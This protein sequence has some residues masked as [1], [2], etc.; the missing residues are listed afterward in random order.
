MRWE[1]LGVL[2]ET[3]VSSERLV[4]LIRHFEYHEGFRPLEGENGKPFASYEE[5]CVAGQPFGLGYARPDIE[6]IIAE[7]A[8]IEATAAKAE[9]AGDP[10]GDRPSKLVAA[11]SSP[12]GMHSERLTARIARDRPGILE[13]MKVGEFGSVRATAKEAGIVQDPWERRPLSLHLGWGG[14]PNT[15]GGAVEA[16]LGARAAA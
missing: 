2:K 1:I 7:R 12:T 8:S 11:T 3:T 16:E 15:R 14:G 10:R 5:F 13:R 4:L 9:P 6:R